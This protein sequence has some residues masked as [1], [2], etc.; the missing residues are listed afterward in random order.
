MARERVDAIIFGS[1][2]R[3]EDYGGVPYSRERGLSELGGLASVVG[4]CRRT[5]R[6][7]RGSCLKASPAVV[8]LRPEAYIVGDAAGH[9]YRR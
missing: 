7:W 6:Y 4:I 2:S 1:S 5:K 3:L 8:L 9:A